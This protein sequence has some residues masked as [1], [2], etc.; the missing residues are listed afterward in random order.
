MVCFLRAL[1]LRQDHAL[2]IIA[3]WRVQ[4]SGRDPERPRRV[5][6]A[7]GRARLR[8]RLPVVRA[9]PQLTIPGQRRLRARQPAQRRARRSRRGA[10]KPSRWSAC[11]AATRAP[12]PAQLSGGQ[13][14]RVVHWH[15][16]SFSDVVPCCCWTS[17]R[18]RRQGA[19]VCGC[20]RSARCSAPSKASR[21]SWSRTTRKGVGVRP[22]RGHA[23]R[24]VIEQIGTPAGFTMSARPRRWSPTSGQ[25]S[26]MLK[27]VSTARPSAIA[28]AAF[29]GA[30]IA[31]VDIQRPAILCASTDGA[32]G[33]SH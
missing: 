21:P 19:S 2:R 6:R 23:P 3:G 20:A 24:R 5:Q 30:R 31:P 16:R 11:P 1:G 18:A 13:Q 12:Y 26:I 9:V 17:R 22:H 33:P 29:L 28:S 7:A 32:R 8:H 25:V 10:V 4:T 27:G 14:Q 15:Q